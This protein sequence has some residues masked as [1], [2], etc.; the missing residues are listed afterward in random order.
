MSFKIEAVTVLPAMVLF[1]LSSYV[2]VVA[3]QV[4]DSSVKEGLLA[5]GLGFFFGGI[6]LAIS[7]LNYWGSR[8][9]PAERVGRAS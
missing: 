2:T 6:V 3:L 4:A 8:T 1:V 7:W 9:G 5:M